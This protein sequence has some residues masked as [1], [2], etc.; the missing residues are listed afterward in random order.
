VG[1]LSAG[2]PVELV[3]RAVG[4]RPPAHITWW[5]GSQQITDVTHTVM[6]GGNVTTGS[7]ILMPTRQDDGKQVTCR[8]SNPEIPHSMLED[9]ALL[10][11]RYKPEV[12]LA[13]GRALDPQS[14]KEG[15]DVYFDCT[16]HANPLAHRVTWY[17]N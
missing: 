17:H 9:T 15:D 2:R 16:I 10:T 4:S 7:I 8:A 12:E 1:S 5:R 6:N 13:L 3:C 14:I 11:I